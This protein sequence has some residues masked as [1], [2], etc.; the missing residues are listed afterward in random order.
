MTALFRNFF[1]GALIVFLSLF[2]GGVALSAE[3]DCRPLQIRD[4]PYSGPQEF[5]QGLL[6]RVSKPGLPVS[7][8]FGTIHVAER[9]V[10][11]QLDQVSGVL[12]GSEVFVME[13]VFDPDGM[14]TLRKMMFFEGDIQLSEVISADL[15]ARTLAILRPYHLS[16][17]DIA[18]MKP[19]AAY[20]TMS[21]P[22]DM[23][24][25]LD[26]RL[27]QLAT[28]ANISVGGL[29]TLEE[30]GQ[31]F[32]SFSRAD[33]VRLLTDA[34]CHRELMVR[35]FAE[36]IALYTAGDLAGLSAYG[37]RYSFE[38]NTLYETLTDKLLSRRNR[39]MV[40]RMQA[41]LTGGN[42]FIA[43]GALHLPGE[44]GVLALL[45]QRGFDITPVF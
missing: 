34:V 4:V 39:L 2:C 30:Q 5:G 29:E 40:D 10:S 6:W 17:R 42:A 43:V 16:E 26:Q 12:T 24:V 33:Q 37:Q 1:R 21:Y 45:Q 15:Y 7:H 8:V 31:L 13:A 38:D 9:H 35:D 18:V 3:L 36:M 11:A 22:A 19:W 44:E 25:I 32:N 27:L 23:G 14:E 20:L 28:S 41:V